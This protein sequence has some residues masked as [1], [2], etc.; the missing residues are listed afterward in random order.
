MNIKAKDLMRGDVFR[1]HVYGEVVS[2]EP[3]A[4]GKRVKVH[5]TLENQGGR[6][7]CGASSNDPGKSELGFTDVGSEIEFICKPGKAFHV[8]NRDEDDDDG[9]NDGDNDGGDDD[10]GEAA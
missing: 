3:V 8:Y 6:A 10:D 1:M 2:V 4:G 9:D 5:L 7:N